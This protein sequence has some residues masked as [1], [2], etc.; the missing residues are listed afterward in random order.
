MG[1]EPVRKDEKVGEL[2]IWLGKQFQTLGAEIEKELLVKR[3][4]VRGHY[5][6]CVTQNV[7]ACLSK[8]DRVRRD[9]VAQFRG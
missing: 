5:S 1:L 3:R 6:R 2:R 4:L 7:D 9:I 8:V